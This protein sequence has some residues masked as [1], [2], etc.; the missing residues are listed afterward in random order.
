MKKHKK[1]TII[2]CSFLLIIILLVGINRLFTVYKISSHSDI[3]FSEAFNI[4]EYLKDEGVSFTSAETIGTL[5]ISGT[6]KKYYLYKL[7]NGLNNYYYMALDETKY[8]SAIL[9]ADCNLVCGMSDDLLKEA[10]RKAV[11]EK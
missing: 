7:M 3:A 11:E 4:A 10:V 8:P 9:D 2:I 5:E 1:M 6:T